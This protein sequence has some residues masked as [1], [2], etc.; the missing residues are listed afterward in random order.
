MNAISQV[1]RSTYRLQ[2]HAK[3]GF[4]DAARV[5]PYLRDLGISHVYASPYFLAARGSTHGYDIADHNQL[6]PE[7]GSAED[8]EAYNQALAD[9]GLSQIVDFVPNHMGIADDGNRW[10]MD[11]L[12]NGPSSVYSGFFDID[13]NPSKAELKNKVLLPILGNQYGRELEAGLFKVRFSG[14]AFWLEYHQRR[15]PLAP[16]S[17]RPILAGAIRRLSN[18]GSAPPAE[19]ESIRTAL[20]HLP[21]SEETA[22]EKKIERAREKEVIKRRLRTLCEESPEVCRALEQEADELSTGRGPGGIDALDAL[23]GA[24]RYRPAYWRVAAEEINYRRFFDIN[25]LAAIRMEDPEVFEASHRLLL[26]WIARG[27]VTGVRI[28]HVDGLYDPRG[29]LEQ[30]QQRASEARGPAAR[31]GGLYLLVEK[32]LAPREHL[33]GEW[34]VSGTTGYEFANFVTSLQVDA[35]A[36]RAFTDIYT[37]FTRVPVKYREV[38]YRAKIL[39]MLVSMS[40]EVNALGHLLNRLSETNR[41]YRDFTLNA[42]TRALRAIIA[43]FAVYRTYLSPGSDPDP[44]DVERIDFALAEAMRRNPALE[45]SVFSFVRDV[46]IPP[47][48]NPHPLEEAARRHFVLKFQQNT[49]PITA[50]GVEDTAFYRYNRLVALNEVGGEPSDFGSTVE[51]FHRRNTARLAEFPHSLLATSTH[52]T[53]RGEDVR[54]RLAALSEMPREWSRAC[55]RWRMLNRR[56]KRNV[57]GEESPDANEEYLLYQTLIGTWPVHA[58]WTDAREDYISRM[59]EYLVKATREAKVNSSWIEPNELWEEGAREFVR[60]ILSDSPRNRFPAL[61]LPLAQRAAQ[62]GMVNSLS[63]SVLKLTVPGVPDIYQGTEIWDDSLVD[64]DNR[65][66]VDFARRQKVLAEVIEHSDPPEFLRHWQDG[67]VK[68][69]LIH[70][71]LRLRA[72]SPALFSTGTYEPLNASGAFRDCVVAFRRAAGDRSLVVVVPRL[73]SRV[74]FPPVGDAWGDTTIENL[75]LSGWHDALGSGS[76]EDRGPATLSALL[77]E[78]PVAVLYR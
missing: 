41:W 71:L 61:I 9:H 58:N 68:I 59:E 2:F 33:R 1:P 55:S 35:G 44:L 15:L 67:R 75:D 53:K 12:E 38:V 19:L 23:I 37:R 50:K 51:L 76:A 20:E 64:P 66:P 22:R 43:S 28:D 62:L 77:R 74:G 21:T 24:Q 16:R 34:P 32:I 57:R 70:R 73:T 29:Y 18:E 17:T 6:N 30:L 11:V 69:F 46:L 72:E 40:S 39:T 8:F 47:K 26:E 65:R 7:L 63:Q 31:D 42:L 25:E 60:A 49:G 54:A 3:F 52:D 27:I 56:H 5:V 45:H 36:E 14:G 4:R 48:E 78:F 10:W 13:W